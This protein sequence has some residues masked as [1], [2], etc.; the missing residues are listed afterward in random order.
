MQQWPTKLFDFSSS[1]QEPG[2]QQQTNSPKAAEKAK[3]LEAQ[4]WRPWLLTCFP[5]AFEEEF[6]DDHVKFWE[7]YWSVLLRIR[8]QRK[9]I[10]LGLPIP[11]EF[12]IEDREYVV[13]LILGRGLAKSSTIEASSV[14]RGAILGGGYTLYVCEAQDQAEEHIGNCKILLTHPDSRVAEFYPD[15]LIDENGRVGG[16]KAKNRT[17]LFITQNGW[18]CRAKGLNAKLRGIR[19]GNKRPD[20][21]NLDDIDNDDDSFAVSQKKLKKITASVIPTQARR[22]ATIKYGQNLIIKHGTINRIRTGESDAL[23]ERTVIGVTNTFVNF[24][25]GIDYQ[26]Y[27]DETDGRLRHRILP[28]ART[29]WKGVDLAAAQKFLNDSGLDTFLAEYMNR[30]EHLQQGKVIHA[31][32]EERHVITWSMFEK[33][34]GCRYIP[35]N[36]RCELAGDLG[37]S[38]QSLSAWTYRATAPMNSPLA[39]KK[40]I[41][42]GKTFNRVSI[43]DQAIELWGEMFP[44]DA[45]GKRHFEA[46]T[47]FGAYPELLRMLRLNPR[48]APYLVG[49]EQNPLEK[50]YDLDKLTYFDIAER[51]LQTQVSVMMLSHEKSGEQKTLSQKYGL[52]VHK[53]KD[54]GA[55]DGVAAWNYLL[56]GDYTQP[57]LFKDDELKPDGTYKLG[58]PELFY[59]VDDDQLVAPRDDRGLK[60]HR[61]NI[62]AWEYVQEKLTDLGYREARPMKMNS[63]TCDSERMIHA[64]NWGRPAPLSEK[65]EIE[66][67]LPETMKQS[68]IEQLADGE[69]SGAMMKRQ[70]LIKDLRQELESKNLVDPR[71]RAK[72]KRRRRR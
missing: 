43:D 32:N 22:H 18:I 52:P 19:I 27:I 10:A 57:H 20:D 38:L 37:Y 25:E 44:D 35:K 26:S 54:F 21:I 14:V 15:M 58:C 24:E 16:I 50:R 40:F 2:A 65:E 12:H 62:L 34:T 6:S 3:A 71:I 63:D 66:R 53:T 46:S 8:A 33:L 56:R 64:R 23:A 11:P 1:Q 48:L 42:R 29:T 69:K 49:Y 30:F 45:T 59:I 68:A 36:W 7:L 60:T 67:R 31:Y 47:D 39:G 4:G 55:E 70:V 17:D 61:E 41:Y 72:L 28:A 13:L 51:L 9:Y 5:F